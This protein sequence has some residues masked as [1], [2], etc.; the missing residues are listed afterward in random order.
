MSGLQEIELDLPD[1]DGWGGDAATVLGSMAHH[2][3]MLH[4][5]MPLLSQADWRGTFNSRHVST[6]MPSSRHGC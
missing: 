1:D 5:G 4:H 6:A 2:S 3:G